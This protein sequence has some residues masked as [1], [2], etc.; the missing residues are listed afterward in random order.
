MSFWQ[1]LLVSLPRLRHEGAKEPLFDRLRGAVLKPVEPGPASKAKSA[2]GPMSVEELKAAVKSADDKER[3]IGLVAAPLA[4]LITIIV[5]GNLINHDPA[6]HLKSGAVNPRYTNPALY[7]DLA[8]VL[9]V[10]CVLVLV[11]AML[12]KRLYLGIVLALFGLAIFNLH[13][14]GF[15]VPFILAGAY[16]LVRAYRLNRELRVATGDLPSRP[17]AQGRGRGAAGPRGANKR[18]TP[19]NPSPRRSRPPKPENEKKAG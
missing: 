6:A 15:G 9:V 4:A 18:Y 11:M 7:K 1:R 19:P 17:G 2:D 3:L 13:F 12:R 16:F 10:M 5:I 14:Y 8:I